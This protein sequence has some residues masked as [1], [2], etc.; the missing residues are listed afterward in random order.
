ML[1]RKHLEEGRI[2][3]ISQSG[4]DR[5]ITLEIDMLGNS[6]KIITKKLIFELTGKNSNI[7]LTQNDII[8]DSLKH[9]T[10]A[11]SSYRSIVPGKP[12]V[13]PPEQ[14][15]N[16][17]LTVAPEKIVADANS[18]PSANFLKAFIGSTVGIGKATAAE[19][20]TAADILPNEVQLDTPSCQALSKVINAFQ[21]KI[22]NGQ[23]HAVYAL[24]GKTN[25]VKTILTLPPHNLS[26]GMHVQ[27]FADINTA[28]NYA[29]Q[30]QPIQLP[31]HE[32]LQK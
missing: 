4:L 21:E 15:G 30:L 18:Q 28:I 23:E 32:Q 8:I 2:T 19:L 1:L 9:V 13:A 7:I 24:I 25:Q 27:E 6:S 5:I 14:N 3:K 17:I 29:V 20:L 16:N 11:Q 22:N 10:A 12:Y 31:Q 26:E